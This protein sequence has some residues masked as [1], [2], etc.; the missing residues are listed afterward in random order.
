MQKYRQSF[1]SSKSID[2]LFNLLLPIVSVVAALL[3]GSVML[4]LLNVDPIEAY[5]SLI[6]GATGLSGSSEPL[7]INARA[8]TI[9]KSIPLLFVGVGICIAFRAGVINVGGEG[10]M[11]MGAVFGTILALQVE[12]IPEIF[13]Y[14]PWRDFPQIA[15]VTFVLTAGFIGGAMWGGIAG[16]L[17]AYFN[18]NEILSTIMLNQ[19]A[20]QIMIYLLN[21]P[22]QDPRQRTRA[23]GIAKTIKI[24]EHAR[25]P[26]VTFLTDVPIRLHA[27][28][29]IA[30]AL[31][32]IIYIL[33][34][35]TT[36]GYRLRAVGKNMRAARYAGINVERQIVYSMLWSGGFAGLAGIVQ[37]AGLQYVL[38]TEGSAADFTGN[39]GFNGIVTALFGGLHPIGTIPASIFFGGLLI[40]GQ[41]MQ[42][43]VQIE[44][45]LITALNGLIVVFVVSSQIVSRR[46]ARRRVSNSLKQEEPTDAE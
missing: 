5:E 33:L 15:T 10:Q 28:I 3:I 41:A 12:D 21:G 27:G 24:P 35:R 37:V 25:L 1:I 42:R 32:V 22:I 14:V 7:K 20:L 29:F 4:L 19:I 9:I 13:T 18:V 40:G 30:I 39:A 26:R 34:W 11:M 16:A 44:A 8:E 43:A 45:S 2:V 6:N 23:G 36:F 38:Q 17:K 46:R 31:A